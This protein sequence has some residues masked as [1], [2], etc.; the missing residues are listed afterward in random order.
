[1]KIDISNMTG[2]APMV[3]EALLPDNYAVYAQDVAA[4]S[5]AIKPI[6]TAALMQTLDTAAETIH[7]ARAGAW[8]AFAKASEVVEAPLRDDVHSR[9]YY[10]NEDGVFVTSPTVWEVGTGNLPRVSYLLGQPAPDAAPTV[11]K[12]GTPA[13]TPVVRYY[14]YTRVSTWG[15]ESPPAPLAEITVETGETVSITDFVAGGTSYVPTAKYRIYRSATGTSLASLLF[16]ADVVAGPYEDLLT[17]DQLGLAIPSVLW[18]GPPAGLRGLFVLPNG[19]LAGFVGREIW[20][21]E[22]YLPHAWPEDYR[23]ALDHTCIAGGVVNGSV[24]IATDAYPYIL[25]GSHPSAYA[26]AKLPEFAPCLSARGCILTAAGLTWPSV[27]GLYAVGQSGSYV[28]RDKVRTAEWEQYFPGTM[29]GAS[30]SGGYIGFYQNVAGG[31]DAVRVELDGTFTQLSI[32]AKYATNSPFDGYVYAL[33]EEGRYILRL[34]GSTNRY[35]YE[36]KSKVFR[37]P[38][39]TPAAAR[40]DYMVDWAA[41]DFGIPPIGGFIDDAPLGCQMVA[42]SA[43]ACDTDVPVPETLQPEVTFTLFIEGTQKYTQ[44]VTSTRPFRLPSGYRAEEIQ[45]SIEA[46]TS[47]RRVIIADSMQETA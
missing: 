45:F 20:F 10:T 17:D 37:V 21:S 28:T 43:V 11:T 2:M 36:W 24:I 9:V 40:V 44:L 13:G 15:E 47:V 29:A 22:P 12:T 4:Y 35:F 3:N 31:W 32:N 34:E 25:S 33:S 8:L 19:A 6:R 41:T 26:P 27:E 30:V 18:D 46:N 5:G 38:S 1:M 16:V 42:G 14:T 23:I 39:W 7:R